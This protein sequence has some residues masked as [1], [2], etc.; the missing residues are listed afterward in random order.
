MEIIEVRALRGP[1]IWSRRTVLQAVVDLGD[2]RDTASNMV[3]GFYDR[4]VAWLPSLIEHRCGVGVRGGFL[5]RLQ[6]GTYPA[7]ILEHVAIEL[8]NLAGTPVGF[9]KA[10][11]TSRPGVYR[12][13][14]RYR[15]EKVARACLEAAKD[16]VL[17]A[18]RGE[19]FDVQGTIERLKAIA[20]DVCLGPSTMAIVEAAEARKIPWMRLSEQ[21]LVQLGHGAKQRRIWTT[22]TDRTSA[23]AE[24]LAGDKQATRRVLRLCGVPVPDGQVVGSPEEA[25]AA[26][27]D[28]GLPVVVK[29]RDG[30][31]GRGVFLELTTQD[32]VV[33]AFWVASREGNGV[34]VER[35]VPGEEHRLLVVGGMVVSAVRGGPA[36]VVG[37]GRSTIAELIE[38]QLNS[39]PR[40]GP[41]DDAPLN[42]VAMDDT[43]RMELR[44]QG[45]EPD[46]VPAAAQ[47]VLIQRNGNLAEDVTALVHPEVAAQAVLAAR[48]VGLDVAG[49]DLVTP[50]VSRPLAAVGGA[51]VEVNAGPALHPHRMPA[52]P[53]AR[54]VGEAILRT[55]FRDGEDG[56]IPIVCV[57]GLSLRSAVSRRLVAML[58]GRA[59]GVGWAASDGLFLDDRC[60]ARGDH[61][62]FEAAR[63]LLMNRG[64]F[65]VV[66]EADPAGIV[67]DGLGFDA[68]SV[69]VVTDIGP[70]PPGFE[71]PFT[72]DEEDLFTIERCPVDIV[73]SSGAAV[74]DATEPLL[75][76]MAPLCAGEVVYF[77]MDPE[78]PVLREHLDRG[79]RAV[80]ARAG[81]VTLCFNGR[82]RSVGALDGSQDDPRVLLC[83][84][85]TVWAFGVSPEEISSLLPADPSVANTAPGSVVQS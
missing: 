54:P 53:P 55:L 45:F 35:F 43:V 84:V 61:A 8:Q 27:Q 50:D 14:I 18:I 33:E 25:W 59:H 40:R 66:A 80:V 22:E 47:R 73:P 71:D 42:P 38:T 3:P 85:A 51:V 77:S 1:N 6:E 74:L 52:N 62:T 83:S 17:A 60:L 67:K 56:R 69:A 16:L 78:H 64:V 41:G 58:R 46:S 12:V 26:A 15:E 76:R 19:D 20:S 13:V 11:E 75:V 4:L 5:M 2:L 29:P 31:H 36:F 82:E 81:S 49:V 39:D 70:P 37:D 7:H 10:R 24:A 48:V 72:T 79:G 63:R 9:G 21:S 34:L 68:C 23:I 65:V 44:R 30:N 32:Q 28:L 57:T